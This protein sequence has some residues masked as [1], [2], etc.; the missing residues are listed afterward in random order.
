MAL[1]LGSISNSILTSIFGRRLGL[2]SLGY[3]AGPPD[4]R[5]TVNDLTSASTAT[6]I[7]NQGL[8]N[9][10]ATSLATSAAG[11]GFLL[12]NPV[13]GVSFTVANVNANSSAASPGSTALTLLRPSTAFSILSSEGSTET[14]INL[15]PGSAVTLTGLSTALYQVVNRTTLAGVVIN[16]T[17]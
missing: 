7:P 4:I 9:I 1:T 15:T 16:G 11:G 3:L 8:T 2:D 17:T 6:A 10:V 12:S 13:P 5:R 14:T